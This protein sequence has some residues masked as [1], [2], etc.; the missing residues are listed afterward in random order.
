MRLEDKYLGDVAASA[1][2]NGGIT[3]SL[4]RIAAKA[5][6]WFSAVIVPLSLWNLYLFVAARSIDHPDGFLFLNYVAP[7]WL[8]WAGETNAAR[9]CFMAFA[10]S[11]VIAI[12]VNPNVTSL[13]RLYRDRLSKA[14]IFHPIRRDADNDLAAVHP[15]L[16]EID[17]TFC[18]YPIINAALNIEGSPYANKRG[19]NADFFMFTPDY[20]GSDATGYVGAAR[21]ER[22]EAAL[23]LGSAMAIS[24]AA[25]SSN[26][27]ARTIRPLTLT[28]AL[29]NVRLGCWLLNPLWIVGRPAHCKP[30]DPRNYFLLKEMFSRLSE[31]DTYVYLTDGGNIENLGIYSLLKRRCPVIIAVDAEED[32]TMGFGSFLTLERYAR[33]DLGVTIELPWQAIRDRTLAVDK[34][35]A[36]GK[37]DTLDATGPHCAAGEI[38]FGDGRGKGVLLYVKASLTGDEEDYVLDYKRRY[39]DFPHET[40][41]DQFFGEE[42]LEAYRALGF[43]MMQRVLSGEAPLAV[44]PGSGETEEQARARILGRIRTA[45]LGN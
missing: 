38:D 25:I 8:W 32:P 40:T 31:L 37:E 33:I 23:D 9:L 12:F 44:H 1:K 36:D 14:F 18:P 15:K 29:L 3:G 45:I 7:S 10:V 4:K 19:R 24:G 26:M 11:V 27:G 39:P 28:L 30:L 16:H 22:Q 2:R 17:T 21:I 42:Q 5:A 35:F 41:G 6:I 13:F 20:V 43:H 34:I